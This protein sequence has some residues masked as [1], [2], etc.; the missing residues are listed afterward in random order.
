MKDHDDA[1]MRLE[2]ALITLEI[3]PEKA[4]ALV[5]V[6]GEE[7]GE[8]SLS[9]GVPAQVKG[10]PEVVVDLPGIARLRARGPAGSIAEIRIDREK[11]AQKLKALTEAFGSADLEVLDELQDK[12][13]ELDKLLAAAQTQTDTLLADKTVEQIETERVTLATG[14]SRIVADYPGWRD[15]PPDAAA[16]RATADASKRAFLASLDTAEAVR[17]AAQAALNAAIHQRGTIEV[18]I[19][20]TD[21]HERSLANKL[22]ELT[23]DGKSEGEREGELIVIALAW[24][25][26]RAG[27]AEIE[28]KLVEFGEDPGATATTLEK[29]LQAADDTATKALEQEKRM[30]C[31]FGGGGW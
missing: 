27:L 13:T 20:E 29:Q 9:A 25:A 23:N 17:D 24:D 31:N 3:V 22:A 30:C 7:P 28:A 4:G 2:A 11:A 18:R 12:A 26:A 19:E 5:V 6:S 21:R 10:S 8:R 16:L 14:I 15:A 1:R